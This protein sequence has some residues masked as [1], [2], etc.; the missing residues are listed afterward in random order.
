MSANGLDVFDRTI[1]T[2]HIWLNEICSELGPDK[3]IAWKALSVVLHKLRDRLPLPLA[4]HLGAQLPLMI[5]G[6]YYDQFEP[7]RVGERRSRDGFIAEVADALNDG[8]PVN[9]EQAIRSVFGI[10][11]RHVSE[12][13]I[14]KVCDALPHG[15]RQLW[16]TVEELRLAETNHMERR[17]PADVRAF[18]ERREDREDS[19]EPLVLTERQQV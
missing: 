19:E 5:R 8:R 2:T 4:A 10:L 9:A 18:G 16:P 13:Q 17:K 6:I 11:S 1:E 3:H 12:G 14:R 15:L 7:G